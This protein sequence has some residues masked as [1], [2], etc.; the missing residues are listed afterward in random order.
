MMAG[1]GRALWSTRWWVGTTL[2]L[3]LL[4]P[5]TAGA[6]EASSQLVR[7]A[8]G[9]S[10]VLPQLATVQRI[11]IGSPEIADALVVSPYEVVVNAMTLGTTT[12][13]VWDAS[14]ARYSYTIEV[15]VDT[16]ALER[17]LTALFPGQPLSLTASGNA[18][19]VSGA[20]GSPSD[21]QRVLD[22]LA[23]TGATVISNLAVQTVPQV[24]LQVRFAE[25]SRS[26]ISELRS[27]L[28]LLNPDQLE[29]TGDVLLETLS[30][31]LIRFLLLDPHASAEVVLH[32]LRGTR[33]F[34]SLAEPNLIALE[35]QEASFLAGGEFPFPV[36]QALGQI[37]IEWREFGVRLRF[38]PNVDP[39]GNIRLRVAPE[40]SA[41]DFANA[42]TMDGFTIPALTTRRAETEVILRDGQTF[43]IAG[44]MDNSM[45]KNVEKLPFLGDIPILGALFQNRDERQR[46]TELLVLVTP[47]LVTPTDVQPALPTDEPGTWPWDRSLR[48]PLN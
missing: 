40:V 27:R 14:G 31:G 26:A 22:I 9:Q 37:T 15:T 5:R 16:P 36:P 45:L 30:D 23:A 43:A 10:V 24:L 32:A 29:G 17:M 13:L 12:L 35:G 1:N 42:L 46:R 4:C 6:Q 44:L 11:S 20:V 3:A 41:L 18:I 33:S 2:L 39:A 19:V 47:R 28:A 48:L 8:Q 21:A 34:R 38:L 7:V 25:V